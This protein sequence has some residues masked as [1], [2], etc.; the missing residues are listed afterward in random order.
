MG[1]EHG[2]VYTSLKGSVEIN[3]GRIPVAKDREILGDEKRE[4]EKVRFK[5][6][7][8][9]ASPNANLNEE[10]STPIR[11]IKGETMQHKGHSAERRIG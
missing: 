4:L 3:E 8:N 5:T 1:K 2:E 11:E 6:G 9:S 10:I 7:V